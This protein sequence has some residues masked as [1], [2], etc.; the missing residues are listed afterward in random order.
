MSRNGNWIFGGPDGPVDIVFENSWSITYSGVYSSV[1]RTDEFLNTVWYSTFQIGSSTLNI[2]FPMIDEDNDEVFIL[3]L[4]IDSFV[5]LVSLN[6]S[7]G[8][9]KRSQ[10]YTF[11]QAETL[12]YDSSVLLD[13]SFYPFNKDSI[14]LTNN[15]LK[16]M[17]Y[18]I[19]ISK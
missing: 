12:I 7:S 16:T 1:I 5:C 17:N 10:C 6:Y 15:D 4:N 11:E 8:I 18:E 3:T 14:I 13:I 2:I 19:M 9:Y